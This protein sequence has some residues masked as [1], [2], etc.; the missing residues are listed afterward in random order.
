M[1]NEMTLGVGKTTLRDTRL[2]D[3]EARVAALEARNAHER[4]KRMNRLDIT[5]AW[6]VGEAH[7][8]GIPA[9][10]VAE[11]VGCSVEQVLAELEATRQFAVEK[12]EWQAKLAAEVAKL[13]LNKT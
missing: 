13:G 10:R 3:L 2:H 5:A 8:A 9:E 4:A 12:A 6:R 1:A 7:A 11:L